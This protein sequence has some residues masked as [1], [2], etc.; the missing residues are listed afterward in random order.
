MRSM[1]VRGS[2][3][4][5]TKWTGMDFLGDGGYVLPGALVPVVV[6]GGSNEGSYVEPEIWVLHRLV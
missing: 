1:E 2:L 5:W 6:D 4:E 3:R